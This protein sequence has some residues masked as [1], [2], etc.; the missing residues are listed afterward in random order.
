MLFWKNGENYGREM[1][2]PEAILS[3]N[4]GRTKKRKVSEEKNDR[5]NFETLELKPN[6][7]LLLEKLEKKNSLISLI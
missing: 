3:S 1:E 4:I 7:K 2:M 5:N 6:K